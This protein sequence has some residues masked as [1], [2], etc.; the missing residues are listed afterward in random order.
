M[1]P[2]AV[3]RLDS[4]SPLPEQKSSW[5][6]TPARSSSPAI[7]PSQFPPYEV[8]DAANSSNPELITVVKVKKKKTGK[9]KLGQ[10]IPGSNDGS[11]AH[12]DL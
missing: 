5:A 3:K 8:N 4:S 7:P 1:P 6:S 12:V 2:N 10:S 11:S 9:K